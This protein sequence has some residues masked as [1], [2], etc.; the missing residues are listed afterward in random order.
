MSQDWIWPILEMAHF[1]GLSLLF[2]SLLIVDLRVAGV[3]KGIPITLVETFIKF[4]LIGFVINIITGTLFV[5]GDS[6]RYLVNIAFQLKIAAIFIAG[7]NSAYFIRRIQPQI[8]RGLDSDQLSSE[9]RYIALFSLT[10]WTAV[11]ILGRLIPYVE[12]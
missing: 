9:A 2:G 8:Q 4:A 7:A 12:A 5:I 11:I 1:L 3:A 10:L 6:D